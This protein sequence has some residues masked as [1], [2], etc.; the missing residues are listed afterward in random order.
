MLMKSIVKTLLFIAVILG[1]V[2]LYFHINP[3]ADPI[4]VAIALAAITTC[5]RVYRYLRDEFSNRK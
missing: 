4:P 3:N 1:G 2:S 5:R